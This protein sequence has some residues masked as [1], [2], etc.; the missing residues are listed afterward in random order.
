MGVVG[1]LHVC[2]LAGAGVHHVH[3]DHDHWH[4]STMVASH[5]RHNLLL[6]VMLRLHQKLLLL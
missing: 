6:Q 2:S 5:L 4:H 1:L 3:G